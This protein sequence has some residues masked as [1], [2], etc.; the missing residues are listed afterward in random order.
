MTPLAAMLEE[1]ENLSWWRKKPA[2]PKVALEAPTPAPA[3][4]RKRKNR[5]RAVN[6]RTPRRG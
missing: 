4:Q 1:R 6:G 3:K 2:K 5:G